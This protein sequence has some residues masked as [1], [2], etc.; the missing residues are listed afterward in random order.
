MDANAWVVLLHVDRGRAIEPYAQRNAFGD[1]YL[2]QLCPANPEVR[3]YA[4]AVI[5]E[6]AS[7]GVDSILMESFHFVPFPHGYH[8]ERAFVELTPLISFLLSLCFCESCVGT[9]GSRGVDI[10]SLRDAVR[11][12]I[13]RGL[14]SADADP[15]A[16][17]DP[18]HARTMFGGELGGFLDT[19]S[20]VVTSLVRELV[21]TA[22]EANPETALVPIDEGGAIKGYAAGRPTGAPAPSLSWQLGV[23]LRQVADAA[24][25]IEVMAYAS[26]AE[27]VMTD[28][29][30]YASAIP[31]SARL[32]VILRPLRPDCDGPGNLRS[33]VEVAAA[34]N[35]DRLDFYHYGLAPL[36]ALDW[37]KSALT[38]PS[39]ANA[40]TRRSK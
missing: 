37:V 7:R 19:R 10:G 8:H 24:G 17:D 16:I 27:R 25:A 9:A 5:A 3:A 6:I 31:D 34:L 21:E 28:L 11:S 32:G 18:T 29:G 38:T 15:A 39:A 35:V 2:T 23:D 4:R 14:S 22:R 40:P 33:K 36:E 1:A 12:T 30:A 20:D 13:R 26:T